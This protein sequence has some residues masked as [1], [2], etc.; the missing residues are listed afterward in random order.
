VSYHFDN[1]YNRSQHGSPERPGNDYCG[2]ISLV[3]IDIIAVVVALTH[4]D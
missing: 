3:I 1:N 2:G 4:D